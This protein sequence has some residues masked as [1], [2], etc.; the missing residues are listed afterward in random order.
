MDESSHLISH[1][2]LIVLEVS[3]IPG[4]EGKQEGS[5]GVGFIGSESVKQ[6]CRRIALLKN[7]NLDDADEIKNTFDT[8]LL[9]ISPCIMDG[10]KSPPSSFVNHCVFEIACGKGFQSRGKPIIYGAQL[11]LS[12]LFSGQYLKS[13]NDSDI[14]ELLRQNDKSTEKTKEFNLIIKPNFLSS[15]EGDC[16]SYYDIIILSDFS[17]RNLF[18][19]NSTKICFWNGSFSPIRLLPFISFKQDQR[20]LSKSSFLKSGD[21][22]QLYHKEAC[23]FLCSTTKGLDKT[24]STLH[25]NL[26]RSEKSESKS[27]VIPLVRQSTVLGKGCGYWLVELNPSV[28][29]FQLGSIISRNSTV[30]FKNVLTESYLSLIINKEQNI[31]LNLIDTP[32]SSCSFMFQPLSDSQFSESSNGMVYIGSTSRLLHTNTMH[33]LTIS[34]DSPKVDKAFSFTGGK[35]DYDKDVY[36][37]LQSNLDYVQI[38]M[39]GKKYKETIEILKTNLQSHYVQKA[40]KISTMQKA[41]NIIQSMTYPGG[42]L[43]S[44]VESISESNSLSKQIYCLSV[45]VELGFVKLLLEVAYIPY[46]LNSASNNARLSSYE[47]K[48]A[49]ISYKI[50]GTI[51]YQ[52]KEAALAVVEAKGMTQMLDHTLQQK[53]SGDWT[54]PLMELIEASNCDSQDLSTPIALVN[55]DNIMKLL[56]HVHDKLKKGLVPDSFPYKF[57]SKLCFSFDKAGSSYSEVHRKSVL[58]DQICAQVL[59]S[60]RDDF[61]FVNAPF[62]S[63]MMYRTILDNAIVSSD[64]VAGKLLIC[65]TSYGQKRPD[66]KR[67]EVFTA[68]RPDDVPIDECGESDW[69]EAINYRNSK[70]CYSA[71]KELYDLSDYYQTEDNNVVLTVIRK[72]EHSTKWK[73]LN[74]LSFEES[75]FY[76]SCL[77][78]LSAICSGRNANTQSIARQLVPVDHILSAI[79]VH[80]SNGNGINS[81]IAN[82]NIRTGFIDLLFNLYIDSA[83]LP[84][85]PVSTASKVADLNV[86]QGLT[87]WHNIFVDECRSKVFSLISQVDEGLIEISD[88]MTENEIQ[89]AIDCVKSPIFKCKLGKNDYNRFINNLNSILLSK[90]NKSKSDNSKHKL[91]KLIELLKFQ[92]VKQ[93]LIYAH[94][95]IKALKQRLWLHKIIRNFFKNDLQQLFIKVMDEG[96]QD[97]LVTSKINEN[98]IIND[99]QSHLDYLNS[100]LKLTQSLLLRRFFDYDYNINPVFI[101]SSH[102]LENLRNNSFIDNNNIN[103]NENYRSQSKQPEGLFYDLSPLYSSGNY[104]KEYSKSINSG[105]KKHI[106]VMCSSDNELESIKQSSFHDFIIHEIIDVI[107]SSFPALNT[108]RHREIVSEMESKDNEEK[109]LDDLYSSL[110]GY[111]TSKS[112][113]LIIGTIKVHISCCK[114]LNTCLDIFH[115]NTTQAL[116]TVFSPLLNYFSLTTNENIHIASNNVNMSKSKSKAINKSPTQGSP[117]PNKGNKQRRRRVSITTNNEMNETHIDKFK[118]KARE[119]LFSKYRKSFELI[120][121][122]SD[123]FSSDSMKSL[124]DLVYY[125]DPELRAEAITLMYRCSSRR[126]ELAQTVLNN[127]QLATNSTLVPYLIRMRS[128][129]QYFLRKFTVHPQDNYDDY[130]SNSNVMYI[131]KLRDLFMN[132]NASQQTPLG[133]VQFCYSENIEGS[134]LS[135]PST[136]AQYITQYNKNNNNGLHYH[137]VKKSTFP[138]KYFCNI[139]KKTN[140]TNEDLNETDEKNDQ[141]LSRE[142]KA[143]GSDDDSSSVES[144]STPSDPTDA[145]PIGV[146]PIKSNQQMLFECDVN[147]V[148]IEYVLRNSDAFLQ[149]LDN[150]HIK[151]LFYHNDSNFN[152]NNNSNDILYSY[153]NSSNSIKN[154]NTKKY[155]DIIEP[156]FHHNIISALESPGNKNHQLIQSL[157]L[158]FKQYLEIFDLCFK[159]FRAF[160]A[161]N[162]AN[163]EHIAS[164]YLVSFAFKCR[165]ISQEAS[166]FL[167]ELLFISPS[168]NY[169]I[170]DMEFNLLL[171]DIQLAFSLGLAVTLKD[172][173]FTSFKISSQQQFI[174]NETN[175][176]STLKLLC[177]M[178]LSKSDAARDRLKSFLSLSGI[179]NIGEKHTKSSSSTM[180]RE[181]LSLIQR[182][183]KTGLGV[184]QLS[185]DNEENNN[186]HEKFDK[187]FITKKFVDATKRTTFSRLPIHIISDPIISDEIFMKLKFGL[188]KWVPLP[189]DNPL[190]HHLSMISFLGKLGMEDTLVKL[191]LIHIFFTKPMNIFDILLIDKHDIRLPYLQ[192][193]H[194]AWLGGKRV[195]STTESSI[196]KGSDSRNQL[197]EKLLTKDYHIVLFALFYSF[198]QDFRLLDYML[199]EKYEKNTVTTSSYDNK[200]NI[201]NEAIN[202]LLSDND[203]RNEYHYNTSTNDHNNEKNNEIF[204]GNLNLLIK[205]VIEAVIPFLVDASKLNLFESSNISID[206]MNH[207]NNNNNNNNNNMSGLS[208]LEKGGGFK[209]LLYFVTFCLINLTHNIHF[210]SL[211]KSNTISHILELLHTQKKRYEDDHHNAIFDAFYNH[212]DLQRTISKLIILQGKQSHDNY[213][214]NYNS[215]NTNNNNDNY[216]L[217]D[218]SIHHQHS[219]SQ[220]SLK[221]KYIQEF[222]LVMDDFGNEFGFKYLHLR[223]V[224]QAKEIYHNDKI[225]PFNETSLSELSNEK[226][227]LVMNP[228]N[229]KTFQ[230]ATIH[231]NELFLDSEIN[232]EEFILQYKCLEDYSS[233]FDSKDFLIDIN[234][235]HYN[236]NNVHKINNINHKINQ[237]HRRNSFLLENDY[238]SNDDYTNAFIRWSKYGGRQLESMFQH[239]L[240]S[241]Q[242]F[243]SIQS[244]NN[245][246]N[247]IRNN[248]NRTSKSSTIAMEQVLDPVYEKKH[249]LS[250]K[251]N[252]YFINIF[253]KGL[254]KSRIDEIHDQHSNNTELL[255]SKVDLE[256]SRLAHVQYSLLELNACQV[257][258]K[259]FHRAFSSINGQINPSASKVA[260]ELGIALIGTGNRVMQNALIES[261]Q[262]DF[263]NNVA[264]GLNIHVIDSVRNLIQYYGVLLERND[265][266]NE[267]LVTAATRLMYFLTLLCE[268]HNQ[269]SQLFLGDLKIVSEVANFVQDMSTIL[270]NEFNQA[271]ISEKI[272]PTKFLPK[273]ELLNI[274]RISLLVEIVQS[275]LEALSEFCQGPCFENQL[276]VSRA[277]STSEFSTF[278]EFFGSFQLVAKADNLYPLTSTIDDSTNYRKNTTIE[279]DWSNN[280]RKYILTAFNHQGLVNVIPTNEPALWYGND[281]LSILLLKKRQNRAIAMD[282]N[283]NNVIENKNNSMEISSLVNN[284]INELKSYKIEDTMSHFDMTNPIAWHQQKLKFIKYI[285]NGKKNFNDFSD[286]DEMIDNAYS[287]IN[288]LG[289]SLTALEASCLKFAAS[290]LE[291]R[292]GNAMDSQEHE[293]VPYVVFESI[294]DTNI[295]CNMANYWFRYLNYDSRQV[296]PQNCFERTMAYAYYSLAKRFCDLPVGLEFKVLVNDWIEQFS[297]PI[298]KHIA[299]IE[300]RDQFK[301]SIA[302]VYFPIP[303]LVKS[304]WSRSDIKA[305]L[306]NI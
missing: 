67:G 217:V 7:S 87:T 98:I 83:V 236:S 208:I 203:N 3:N 76:C 45:A 188:I 171:T 157:I 155:D 99:S 92:R 272:L 2:D 30:C 91:L 166:D 250:H 136:V 220:H 243:S 257:V 81:N 282:S 44:C 80:N 284:E 116:W 38:L 234:N 132:M 118:L 233:T 43:N 215:N 187:L 202:A 305:L 158:R 193:L 207:N 14:A 21:I 101:N 288:S 90:S 298:D 152:I 167:T 123:L 223:L 200:I 137:S 195:F 126:A 252:K 13:P 88:T 147:K 237:N 23:A 94:L 59:G 29:K 303:R 57:L 241:L 109:I 276:I 222:I 62:W 226:Y 169:L 139:W 184:Y 300:V 120:W 290:L 96:I 176:N 229:C 124:L 162:H 150:T 189:P 248:N 31:E 261:M 133:I 277:G 153:S 49:E 142:P 164:K 100:V 78:L 140:K 186:E 111:K 159:F 242:S 129:I 264:I 27:G 22:I 287:L 46:S 95:N 274:E 8:S 211:M 235:D 268:G 204:D 253:T 104:Y 113:R 39:V 41:S 260:I 170:S 255:I 56:D 122:F 51:L 65:T 145:A 17:G 55:E 191:Q 265:Q 244:N 32:D 240:D 179:N 5:N 219:R 9:S 105:K 296:D 72:I 86:D 297:I 48:L 247:I 173:S 34:S 273:K 165:Y 40:E 218:S 285:Q 4:I 25:K 10:D 198:A 289:E 148:I 294:V 138:K 89:T 177:A 79:D 102:P 20:N 163:A 256:N 227:L 146:I 279:R 183:I 280:Y 174:L 119:V 47:N 26:L 254:L 68:I 128:D 245:S 212:L 228:L 160:I 213:D 54:P 135:G 251:C 74:E 103:V 267:K 6:A 16:I 206:E 134:N 156:E 1:G 108:R 19:W 205:Y 214:N 149:L 286:K 301:E 112:F 61:D 172:S 263:R 246:N 60:P 230:F 107:K 168:T 283:S 75:H 42:L 178:M 224:P 58:Q 161:E 302:V 182:I 291:G 275:G 299:R 293:E 231:F 117:S 144:S 130:E 85:L 36:H 82:V 143:P 24:K 192:L 28:S 64:R 70:S 18:C 151:N 225:Y 185:Y 259:Q 125:C 216:P 71:V 199:L 210:S 97:I 197:T 281:P 114:I 266:L 131:H 258:V 50:L 232:N 69:V 52:N 190:R 181:K 106:L 209:E 194:G 306:E 77:E 270:A 292:G 239:L 127:F 15:K 63:I 84:P 278:F 295:L 115:S 262:E 53:Q 175:F 201:K 73:P 180:S 271:L 249:I 304:Y 35:F 66:S 141:F 37:I 93:Q 110:F 121:N 11:K 33:Y 221:L 196:T 12:L 154:N 238:D 269:K